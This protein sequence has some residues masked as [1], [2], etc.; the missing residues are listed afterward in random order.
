MASPA[1]KARAPKPKPET[2]PPTFE[3]FAA[4]A[5]ESQIAESDARDLFAL[6]Q[7]GRWHDGRGKKIAPWRQKLISYSVNGYLPSQKRAR[8][9]HNGQPEPKPDWREAA[10]QAARESI[11]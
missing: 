11:S 5:A 8:N 9:N 6:W 10:M 4:Y 3:Q 1:R 2:A 7:A